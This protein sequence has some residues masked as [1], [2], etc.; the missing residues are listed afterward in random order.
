MENGAYI[1]KPI[2]RMKLTAIGCSYGKRRP[3]RPAGLRRPNGY[4]VLPSRTW[5]RVP[6]RRELQVD[7]TLPLDIS[8]PYSTSTEPWRLCGND[9]QEYNPSIEIPQERFFLDI[10]LLGNGY[11]KASLPLSWLKETS[12]SGRRDRNA[13]S[14]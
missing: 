5:L 2:Y 13:A 6:G 9:A 3:A 10:A 11:L 12:T 1:M 14:D 8:L 4:S 7:G